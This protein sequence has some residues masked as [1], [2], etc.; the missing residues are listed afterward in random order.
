MSRRR[1]KDSFHSFIRAKERTPLLKREIERLI[2]EAQRA[3]KS[4]MTLKDG[5]IKDF[6]ESKSKTKRVKLYKNYVFV[7]ARTSTACITMYPLREDLITKQEE[8]DKM[9]SDIEKEAEVDK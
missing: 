2:W 9:M 8:Y 3:G 7:F 6:L 4:Y 1:V 5:P